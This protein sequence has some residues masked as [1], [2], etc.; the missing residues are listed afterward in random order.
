MI[1]AVGQW[2]F[3]MLRVSHSADTMFSE[4]LD[5]AL[6]PVVRGSWP[7][8]RYVPVPMAALSEPPYSLPH[9]AI[10]PDISA[11]TARFIS[12][13][14]PANASTTLY[15]GVSPRVRFDR[16]VINMF[17]HNIPPDAPEIKDFVL[18]LGGVFYVIQRTAPRP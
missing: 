1:E 15:G 8:H 17:R 2:D 4:Q 6:P 18:D 5:V 16:N 9:N 13:I 11:A 12:R 3:G 7:E 10:N 14:Y